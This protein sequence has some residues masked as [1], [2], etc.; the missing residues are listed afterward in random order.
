MRG[1]SGTVLAA[2]ALPALALPAAAWPS[3]TVCE[4]PGRSSFASVEFMNYE[5]AALAMGSDFSNPETNQ[6]TRD[7]ELGFADDAGR[8]AWGIAHRYHIFDFSSAAS[9]IE[10]QTNGHVHTTHVPLHWRFE[11]HRKWRVSIA[12]ALSTSSNVYGHPR[13]WESE[14]FALLAALV[15]TSRVSRRSSFR[16]GLCGDHRFGEYTLYPVAAFLW[17]PAPRWRLELGFPATSIRFEATDRVRSTL[18]AAP[19]G[20]AWHVADDELAASSQLVHEAIALEW[21]TE[22]RVL[23][24]LALSLTLGRELDNRYKMTLANGE[25]VALDGA[26]ADRLGIGIRWTF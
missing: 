4:S 1:F 23:P 7:F 11:G 15:A 14:S 21:T 20:N 19:D 3:P 10:P 12:P 9:G 5:R 6:E 16:Y 26:P 18:G 17:R 2:C 24:T 22:W 25:R 13:E 8:F